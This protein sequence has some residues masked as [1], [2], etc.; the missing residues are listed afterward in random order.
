METKQTIIKCRYKKCNCNNEIPLNSNTINNIVRY[1]NAY[2]HSECFITW[3]KE[4]IKHFK[5]NQKYKD[6]LSNIDAYKE[7]AYKHLVDRIDNDDLFNFIMDRYGVKTLDKYIYIKLNR[8]FNGTLEGIREGGI[9]KE[10]FLDMWKRKSHQLDKIHQNNIVKGKKMNTT[11]TI[12]Y[13]IS[14][15]INKY[16]SYLQW[17]ERE[18]ILK[19]ENDFN[20]SSTE[21]LTRGIRNRKENNIVRDN[22]ISSLVN[23]IFDDD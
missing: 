12:M 17:L 11:Q 2:Y 19:A 5:N 23:D 4:G 14:V 15:L 6:M 18:K 9:P 3:C 8:I 10:H 1:G 13:D 7:D 16:D 22:D 21:M 20:N